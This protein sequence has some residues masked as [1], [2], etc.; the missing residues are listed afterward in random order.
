MTPCDMLGAVVIWHGAS[1]YISDGSA[2][3]RGYARGFHLLSGKQTAFPAAFPQTSFC[4]NTGGAD[5]EKVG[6]GPCAS[7]CRGGSQGGPQEAVAVSSYT[8]GTTVRELR[9]HTM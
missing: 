5:F 8:A 7:A 4:E 1:L 6:C 2:G 9:L 3:R